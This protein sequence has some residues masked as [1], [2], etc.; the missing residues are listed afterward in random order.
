MQLNHKGSVL[1][2]DNDDRI[3][4]AFQEHLESAGFDT[5]A[6]WSGR[7]ALALLGSGKFDVLL[8]DDYLPDIHSHDFLKRVGRLANQP[9]IVVM[10]SA[11]P[12]PADVQSYAALD[13]AEL[14][15]KRDP[16]KVCRA[17]SSCFANHKLPGGSM[18]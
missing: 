3:L 2:V 17:V 10:H 12:K 16:V 15:D 5:E 11:E 8:V 14:V 4:W 7:E 13:V 18:N 1:I 9:S 6:T